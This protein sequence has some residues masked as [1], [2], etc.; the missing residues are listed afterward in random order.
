MDDEEIKAKLQA[1]WTP[2]M[3]DRLKADMRARLGFPSVQRSAGGTERDAGID[4]AA[5]ARNFPRMAK[6]EDDVACANDGTR[7]NH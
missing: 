1:M 4:H 3:W 2:E 6:S 5:G 7:G